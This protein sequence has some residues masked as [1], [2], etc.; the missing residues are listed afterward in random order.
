[1][2]EVTDAQVTFADRKAKLVTSL[3]RDEVCATLTD[4]GT[5]AGRSPLIRR[6]ALQDVSS[7][8]VCV[9]RVRVRV[10]RVQGSRRTPTMPRR[11][12][13]SSRRQRQAT[14]PN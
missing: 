5:R 11:S 12:R 3:P 10:C 1:M 13:P 14:S 7:R 8:V 6:A 9:C 4:L 2:D